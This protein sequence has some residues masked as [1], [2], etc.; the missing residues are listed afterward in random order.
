MIKKK[1]VAVIPIKKKSTRVKNKNFRLINK[2][3][4]YRYLLDNLKF[5]NFDE[6]YVDSDSKEIEEYCK[7]ANYN[8]I[9]R[10]PKLARDSASGND[11]LNYHQSVVD[12]DY[13]FQLYITAPLLKVKTINDCIKILKT[14][15]K[16]DSIFTIRKI[17][18]WFWFDDRPINYNPKK[19]PRS[20]DA[21]PV[22]QETTGLY[23]IKKNTLKKMKCRIGKKPFMYEVEE[24]EAIDLDEEKD[25]K[26]LEYYVKNIYS[27]RR[28]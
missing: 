11:V 8:F 16:I 23:G 12:A 25:F 9:K 2:K 18:S 17:H 27:S 19:L 28:S 7:R 13:F 14:N 20:Q 26:Y 5:C 4:L 24:D 10:L 1:V 21:K 3:P 22:I 6:V 15:K